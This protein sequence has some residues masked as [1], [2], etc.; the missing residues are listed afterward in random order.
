MATLSILLISSVTAAIVS[1]GFLIWD[2]HKR[3]ISARKALLM[4]YVTELVELFGRTV[5]YYTQSLGGGISYSA[6]YEI[7][8]ENMLSNFAGVVDQPKVIYVIVRLKERYF[9]IRRHADEASKLAIEFSIEGAK[10]QALSKQYGPQDQ[11]V[12][13]AQN[14]VN[15][16]ILKARHAQSRALAFFA[17]EQMIKWTKIVIAYAKREIHTADVYKLESLFYQRVTEKYKADIAQLKKP[18][19]DEVPPWSS[20]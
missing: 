10:Y 5:M 15:A 20:T 3:R 2:Y 7:S 8:Q 11:R 17:F 4:A 9:Q 14:T 1:S 19:K 18:S 6:L 12:Q 16:L 13:E